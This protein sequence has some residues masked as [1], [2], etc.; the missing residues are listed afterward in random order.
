[1]HEKRERI[2]VKNRAAFVAKVKQ[3]LLSRKQELDNTLSSQSHEKLT[4]GVVQDS[5]DEA[6]SLSMETLQN[7]LQKT[8][9]D[10]LH[11]METAL[12]KIERDEYGMCADCNEPIS[13]KR[14]EHFPFAARCIVCQE[15]AEQ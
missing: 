12:I 13:E 9:L 5:A 6:L 1:M 8:E 15:A 11:M 14:L 2:V 4:D 3:T 7:S 10:E